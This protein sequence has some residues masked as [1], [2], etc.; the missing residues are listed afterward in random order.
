VWCEPASYLSCY[1]AI[2]LLLSREMVGRMLRGEQTPRAN[3]RAPGMCSVGVHCKACHPGM[4][5]RAL[6]PCGVSFMPTAYG[7]VLAGS[8]SDS[9]SL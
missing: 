5:C 8:T 6:Q 4:A 9:M 1:V 7:C 2:G 3:L